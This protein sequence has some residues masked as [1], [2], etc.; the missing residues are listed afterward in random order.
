MVNLEKGILEIITLQPRILS[1]YIDDIIIS[2][3]YAVDSLNK[4]TLKVDH[5]TGIH[6]KFFT[7]CGLKVVIIL[8]INEYKRKHWSLRKLKQNVPDDL[9]FPDFHKGIKIHK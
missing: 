9:V 1:R 5:V 2:W 8:S 6:E 3:E 4:G 7:F